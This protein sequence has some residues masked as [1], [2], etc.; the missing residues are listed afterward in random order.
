VREEEGEE[1]E[2]R[3]GAEGLRRYL[4]Q[5]LPEYMVPVVYVRME[6]LP[7]SANGKVDRKALPAPEGDAYGTHRYEP[8]VGDMERAVAGIWAELVKVEQIGRQDNF[9]ELGGHSLLAVRVM[10]RLWQE[11]GVEATI[12]DLFTWPILADLARALESAARSTLP[13]IIRVERGGRLP[14][15]YAP[16]RLWVFTQMGGVSEAYHIPFGV[17]LR[18]EL[19]GTAL[20]QALDRIV[21]RHEALRTT[22][23]TVDGE[24]VQRIKRVEESDF[25][26]VE[27][28]L[29]E[30]GEEQGRKRELERLIVEEA[31]APF[32]LE[33]GPVVRGR[34]IRESEREHVLLITM[35][36][37]VSD[38]W[39][40]GVLMEELSVLY[41]ARARAESDPLPELPVQYADYAVWQ[42]RRIEDEVL[43]QQGEYW[44]N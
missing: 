43:E 16:Q 29:E 22:F 1:S 32:D 20:R 9:F 28:D 42:R 3:V 35:H 37:I 15:S 6:K 21:E 23:V 33:G 17:R 27:H 36:H 44:K 26:L 5:R 8:P 19:N 30:R 41:G 24:P 18:G 2:G 10:T 40:I 11:L 39:S 14:L 25:H 31:R 38:G 13:A 7:L 4:G 12:Q 34:L